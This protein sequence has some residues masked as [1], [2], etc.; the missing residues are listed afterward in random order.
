MPQYLFLILPQYLTVL[1]YCHN[2]YLIVMPQYSCLIMM[3]QYFFLILPQY[4]TVLSYCHN[5]CLIMMPQY[6]SLIMMPQYL[7][8]LS[9]CHDISLSCWYNMG[10]LFATYVTF[11]YWI[12]TLFISLGHLKDIPIGKH[13]TL[14]LYPFHYIVIMYGHCLWAFV[15]GEW[16][17]D[18]DT[19]H[20]MHHSIPLIPSVTE[21]H[22]LSFAYV[23]L[24]TYSNIFIILSCWYI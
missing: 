13:I 20:K 18:T 1:S 6:L 7:T 2:I 9:C 16:I 5:I 12:L 23:I 22:F 17:Q 19:Q 21:G 8:F 14:H 10:N 24:G 3:P 4:L 15:W 11:M